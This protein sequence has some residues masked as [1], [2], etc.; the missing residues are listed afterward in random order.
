MV[1]PERQAEIDERKRLRLEREAK[2]KEAKRVALLNVLPEPFRPTPEAPEPIPPEPIPEPLTPEQIRAD[3]EPVGSPR[4]VCIDSGGTWDAETQTC[5]L[6]ERPGQIIITDAQGSQRIQTPQDVQRE[7]AAFGGIGAAEG[8]QQQ[9]TQAAEQQRV[10]QILSQLGQV[11]VLTSAQQ[12]SVN[13][14]QAAL[15]GGVGTLAG[16]ATGVIGGALIGGKVG[17]IAGVPGIAIGVGLGAIGGFITGFIS[18]VKVQQ[19]GEIR[20][21]EIELT[22][23]R[24]IMRGMAEIARQDPARAQEYKNIYNRQLTRVHQARRQLKAEVSGDLNSW[25]NDGRDNLARFDIFIAEEAPFYAQKLE[26]ALLTGGEGIPF[27]DAQLDEMF[28]VTGE[29]I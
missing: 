20:A 27:T 12:A 13:K 14:S 5:K 29:E 9:Q 8:L 10:Q 11:G 15:A 18:N 28:G 6:E 7:E 17:A 3:I 4:R 1:T 23:A 26:I 21:A 19:S 16:I 24:K 2:E 25:M 22:S